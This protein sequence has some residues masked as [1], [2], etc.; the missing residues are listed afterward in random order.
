MSAW[1][2]HVTVAAIVERDGRFLMV[3]EL[4]DGKAMINQPAGHLE[5]GETIID[6]TI[7]ET[8]EE[9]GW[10]IKPTAL[11]GLQLFKAANG[12]TYYRNTLAAEPLTERHNHR[13]DEGIIAPRWMTPEQLQKCP[14]LRSPMVLMTLRQYLSG[15]RYPLSIFY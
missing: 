7:R 13:L 11:V 2:A 10:D 14:N 1:H 6:A 12:I 15:Q 9:T 3:E 8:L 4:I 5:A